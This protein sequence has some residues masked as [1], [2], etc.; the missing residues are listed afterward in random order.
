MTHL[1]KKALVTNAYLHEGHLV[2]TGDP[3]PLDAK[4]NDDVLTVLKGIDL[5]KKSL[6]HRV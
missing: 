5:L 1:E 4:T 6:H 2:P 3:I